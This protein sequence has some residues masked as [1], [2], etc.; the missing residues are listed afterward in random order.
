I[1]LED[2][3]VKPQQVVVDLGYRGKDVDAANPGVQ[4][5]HRGRYKTMSQH[6]RQLLKRRQAVE[7]AIGHLKADYR[8]RRCWL[9][10]AAGDALHALCCAVGYN[11]ALADAGRGAPGPEGPFVVPV[12]AG[13][14]GV[15]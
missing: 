1:M 2:I 7:P 13:L 10:G 8:M 11:L 14:W 12:L 3:G 15:P 9:A 5:I 6:E 4:I